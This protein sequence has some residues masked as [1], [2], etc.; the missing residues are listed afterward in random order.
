MKTAKQK[1]ADYRATDYWKQVVHEVK[2]RAG[3]RCQ[4]CNSQH[5]LHAHH[6]TYENRGR[7]LAH[8]DD[9]V[10]LCR[11][12]HAIFHG[13]EEKAA[14][15]RHA[16]QRRNMKPNGQE[17]IERDMPLV[18]DDTITLTKELVDRCRTNGVFTSATVLGLGLSGRDMT[19]GWPE[20][21]VGRSISRAH[22]RQA[23]AGRYVYA[24]PRRA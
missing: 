14:K 20:R 3:W 1:Y 17:E 6:R 5:D 21:L 23:L 18:V 13:V 16:E 4:I 22:Y 8:L 9:L 15:V 7:E 11:R 24:T 12:C 10:C 19:R 2:A